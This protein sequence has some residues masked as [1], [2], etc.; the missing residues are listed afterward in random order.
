[1]SARRR[2]KLIGPIRSLLILCAD[3]PTEL[4]IDEITP[5]RVGWKAFG[6]SALPPVWTLPLFVIDADFIAAAAGSNPESIISQ[7]LQIVGIEVDSQLLIRSSGTGE[8]LRQR[9]QLH[10]AQ[11]TGERVT[12]TV[13]ALLERTATSVTGKIHWI[14]QEFHR[15]R[16]CGHF[17]NERRMSYEKRDWVLETE[18]RDGYPGIFSPVAVRKWRDGLAHAKGPLECSSEA[19]TSVCLKH[20]A[21][22]AHQFSQR[23]HFEWIWDGDRVLLVQADPEDSGEGISPAD[24]LPKKIPPV[25]IDDL[26]A[27]RLATDTDFSAFKKLKNAKLYGGLGYS[28]P[29]FYV[30]TDLPSISSILNGEMPQTIRQDLETLTVRPLIIR[31]DGSD[32]PSDK[33]EMLPRSDELRSVDEAVAWLTGFFRQKIIEGSLQEAS[34]GLIAHHFIPS[35]ASAWAQSE[36]S[37]TIVRVESLWGIPEGLYWFSH[38]TFEVDTQSANVSPHSGYSGAVFPYSRKL[39]YKGTFVAPDASGKWISRKT[40]VPFD[41]K[42][43]IGRDS[44]LSEIAW[45]TRQIAEQE[46]E[47]V[48]VMWFVGNHP[49]ATEHSVL[50]WFH[51]RFELGETPKAAPRRK[52]RMSPDFKIETAQDWEELKTR[53]GEGKRIE[54]VVVEPSDASL[55][56]DPQFAKALAELAKSHNLVVELSGGI[57]SHVYYILHRSGAQVECV[58]LFG[59]D[60]DVV[61][62]Y[63]VVRDKIPEVIIRKGERAHTVRLAGDALVLALKQKLVEEAFEALDATSGEEVIG[64]LADVLEVMKGLSK[65]LGVEFD[66]IEADRKEKRK[67]RGGFEDGYMLTK[68]ATPHSLIQASRSSDQADEGTEVSVQESAII[69]DPSQLP[70]RPGYRRPDLRQPEELE[71]EKMLT[72]ETDVNRLRELKEVLSFSFPEVGRRSQQFSLILELKRVRAALRA[73]VRLCRIATQLELPL[74]DRQLRLFHGDDGS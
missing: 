30:L 15:P 61:D 48:S 43:S 35:L 59:G 31:T 58:D 63:K 9:G 20:V 39:R 70:A 71:L 41:W 45:R 34:L 1:M 18:P 16:A 11:C 7:C 69:S 64:E 22:W 62:F 74:N 38:D 21:M 26:R 14:V 33:R 24:I 23:L 40:A 68:T 50:P 8:T 66:R 42:P 67:R 57:L 37:R 52:F 46:K 72:V 54:R 29:P 32:L 4:T 56:R 27:F 36:P 47:P 28:M 55:I 17:S 51:D 73:I 3:G 60:E 44:W 10:S 6:I 53:I 65:V 19:R 2:G 13:R 5:E 12:A 25:E 49:D